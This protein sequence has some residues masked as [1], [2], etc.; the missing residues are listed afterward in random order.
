MGR[1][2]VAT[3]ALLLPAAAGLGGWLALARPA[4]ADVHHSQGA[5]GEA[6][7]V[8]MLDECFRLDTWVFAGTWVDRDPAAEPVG[9]SGLMVRIEWWDVCTD[10]S[11]GSVSGLTYDADVEITR[12]GA[13]ADGVVTVCGLTLPEEFCFDIDVSVDWNVD[14][15]VSV[16]GERGHDP[17][18]SWHTHSGWREG[19]ASGT[20]TV[21]G[22]PFNVNLI[23]DPA[24][25]AALYQ[26]QSGA[27]CK[28]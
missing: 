22:E 27:V 10:T 5:N 12:R 24:V 16:S 28:A 14:G 13:S 8:A 18:C 15:G 9:R 4:A 3:A 6:R 23:P 17:V 2:A 25:Y 20:L 1:L 7:F 19:T 11:F 26:W 21:V